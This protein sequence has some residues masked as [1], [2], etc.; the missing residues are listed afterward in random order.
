MRQHYPSLI[1]YPIR[2]SINDLIMGCPSPDS[3][4]K[5][6]LVFL[7]QHGFMREFTMI[8]SS[9]ELNIFPTLPRNSRLATSMTKYQDLM[10]TNISG[11][12]VGA[13][14]DDNE[15]GS[16]YLMFIRRRQYHPPFVDKL[17]NLLIIVL[18]CV[19]AFLLMLL[20]ISY[21]FY[22]FRRRPDDIEIFVKSSGFNLFK[23]LYVDVV[24]PIDLVDE[25]DQISEDKSLSAPIS[26]V[27]HK[28]FPNVS[29]KFPPLQEQTDNYML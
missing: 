3:T 19:I 28:K 2:L 4:G 9:R 1:K 7:S 12:V 15:L 5:L 14:G 13:P 8:P 25:V 27:I 24:K 26:L 29:D 17:K 20:C 10:G 11:L 23:F 18:P 22:H 21:F 6:F 16:V